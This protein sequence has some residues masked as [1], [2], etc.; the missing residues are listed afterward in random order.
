LAKT[1]VTAKEHVLALASLGNE[2]KI[3]TILSYIVLPKVAKAR[4]YTVAVA[5][6][7][8]KRTLPM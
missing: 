1:S 6:V 8:A 4:T 3:V 5:D 7:F 2:T